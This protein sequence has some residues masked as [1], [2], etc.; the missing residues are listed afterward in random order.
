MIWAC[1]CILFFTVVTCFSV[2]AFFNLLEE[3]KTHGMK[4]E[5]PILWA[6]VAFVAAVVSFSMML[7]F[8]LGALAEILKQ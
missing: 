1:V 7:G 6:V 2:L 4:I 5:Q 8:C 3:A